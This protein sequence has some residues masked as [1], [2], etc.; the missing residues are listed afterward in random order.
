MNLNSID[1]EEKLHSG[2]FGTTYLVKYKKEF[3]AMKIQHIL[4]KDIK[5]NYGSG[6]WREVD[7][8]EWVGKLNKDDILFFCYPKAFRIQEHCTHIQERPVKVDTTNKKDEFAQMIRKLDKSPICMVIFM[9]YKGKVR[10]FDYLGRQDI[11]YHNLYSI[12]LQYCKIVLLLKESGYYHGDLHTQNVMINTTQKENFTLNKCSIPYFGLQISAVDY[13]SVMHKKYKMKLKWF[14]R[15]FYTHYDDFVF[16]QACLDLMDIMCKYLTKTPDP[17]YGK[18]I[19]SATLNIL[20]KYT[21]F[22]ASKAEKYLRIWPGAKDVIDDILK[23][24][25]ESDDFLY[26]M[27]DGKHYCNI[28]FHIINSRIFWEFGLMYP[29][30]TAAYAGYKIVY[31]IPESDIL[32]FM[33]CANLDEIIDLF[34][35]KIVKK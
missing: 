19:G 27:I 32:L 9:E 28:Y 14:K 20:R 15:N 11:P 16:Y 2:M 5:R 25:D 4:K 30:K 7:L 34:M 12:C 21:D 29:E 3:Y 1:V 33:S 13:G 17:K 31:L 10:L 8:F 6:I 26:N 35:G 23:N 18:K 24:K 22:Y